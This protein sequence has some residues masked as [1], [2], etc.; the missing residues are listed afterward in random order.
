MLWNLITTRTWAKYKRTYDFDLIRSLCTILYD[1]CF[2]DIA[3][4]V[5]LFHIYVGDDSSIENTLPN[6]P[7]S[8]R[9]RSNRLLN[10]NK[11]V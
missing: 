4:F 8:S 1:S 10:I 2:I 9:T 11:L 7:I 5:F 6:E 3:L